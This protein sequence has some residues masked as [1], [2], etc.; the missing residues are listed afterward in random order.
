MTDGSASQEPLF[1]EEQAQYLQSL[2]AKSLATAL[3]EEWEKG[4]AVD[5]NA[6]DVAS[7]A[8]SSGE[9]GERLADLSNHV[10]QSMGLRGFIGE[11]P[12]W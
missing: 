8:H 11:M 4:K 6:S 2:V 9:P 12:R 10:G 7:K 3:A 5:K 1:S